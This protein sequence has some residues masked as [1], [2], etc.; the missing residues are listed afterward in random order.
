M[1]ETISVDRCCENCRFWNM[2]GTEYGE[3][4]RSPPV[5]IDVDVP[6]QDD[7]GL[8]SLWPTTNDTDWCGEYLSAAGRL[9]ERSVKAGLTSVD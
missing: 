1:T 9:D 3:C 7:N 6:F 2:R 5:L 4:R 8:V